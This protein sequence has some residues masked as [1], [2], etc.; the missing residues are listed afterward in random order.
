MAALLICLIC[1]SPP[2][3]RSKFSGKLT[4]SSHHWMLS[5]A[6]NSILATRG[7]AWPGQYSGVFL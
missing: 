5:K 2:A 4:A 6:R 1:S 3:S 7:T